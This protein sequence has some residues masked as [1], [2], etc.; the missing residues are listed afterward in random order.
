M[1]ELTDR[2]RRMLSHAQ[3]FAKDAPLEA[4]A[5]VRD[6]AAFARE[7]LP[8]ASAEERAE[9]ASLLELAEAREAAYQAAFE[10]W[11]REVKARA[12]LFQQHERER[13][14]QPLPRKV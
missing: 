7:A 11:S 8:R 9:V 14:Q 3:D 10:R 12:E 1:S 2:L 5:R 13:L 6:A 4:V